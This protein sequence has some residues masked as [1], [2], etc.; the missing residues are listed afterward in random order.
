MLQIAGL[1]SGREPS[2]TR[3]P[4]PPAVESL[5]RREKRSGAVRQRLFANRDRLASITWPS[6][7][8]KRTFQSRY[9]HSSIIIEKHT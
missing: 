8:H 6:P 7:S 5:P 4:V 1:R 3:Q 2:G 9:H